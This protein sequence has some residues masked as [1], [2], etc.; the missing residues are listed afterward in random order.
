MDVD[1]VAARQIV[2]E[3]ADCLHERHRLDVADGAADLAENE[4]VS[5]I[6]VED[7]IL[8]LV[9]NVRDH[10]HRRAQIIAAP[11]LGDD[12]LVDATGR[13]VVVLVR[14]PS[15][16]ALVVPEIEIRFRAVVGHED[17]AVLVGRHSCPDRR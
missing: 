7:E 2:A 14:R 12:V 15:R 3:L 11:F 5:V 1:G 9:G 17:L 8:D 10:L 16:K 4:V 6:A 13:D